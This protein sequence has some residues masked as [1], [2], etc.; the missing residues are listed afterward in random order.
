MIISTLSIKVPSSKKKEIINT[1]DYFVGPVS[2]QPGCLSVKLYSE[3]NTNNGKLL[4]VEIWNS[5][6]NLNRHIR[7]DEFR[8]IL[9]IMD[10]AKEHPE[11]KFH[12]ISST[13]GFDLV[14]R[15]RRKNEV[16]QQ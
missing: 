3:V 16:S 13:E 2:V 9:A 15:L 10:I 7:S 14:E 6:T 11:I 5:Q 12:T 4:L 1:F 8:K